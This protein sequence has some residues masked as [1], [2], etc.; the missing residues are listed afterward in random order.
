MSAK[1][2][3]ERFRRGEHRS[4]PPF[5]FIVD[6]L[7]RLPRGDGL[8]ALDLACGS[9]R[10]AIALAAR[11]WKV[12]A[13][14]HSTTA[15][16]WLRAQD[17]SIETI[18][19]DLEAHAYTIERNAWDLICVSFY[20]QRDLFP[21]IR[22]GI[23]PGGFIAA[24]FPMIDEREGIKPMNSEFLMQPGELRSLFSDFEPLHSAEPDPAPPKRRT[25]ELFARK[26]A[27]SDY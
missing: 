13:V 9:G 10:H 1:S 4:D 6:C 25:A 2:W 12:T 23:K 15:L 19:A 20:M 22:A 8:R 26:A 3:D 18:E 5:A 24:A 27:D 7:G 14:D 16:E 17:Q 21:S 11:G